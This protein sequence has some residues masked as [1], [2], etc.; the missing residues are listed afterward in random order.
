MLLKMHRKEKQTKKQRKQAWLKEEQRKTELN[1]ST[2]YLFKS[3]D[4]K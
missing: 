1:F 2:Q 3:F 4:R